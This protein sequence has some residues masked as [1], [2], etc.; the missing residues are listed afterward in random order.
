MSWPIVIGCGVA[1]LAILYATFFFY[2]YLFRE[3]IDEVMEGKEMPA[4]TRRASGA[5]PSTDG[6]LQRK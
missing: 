6:Q 3:E 4:P 1:M 2:R 5:S